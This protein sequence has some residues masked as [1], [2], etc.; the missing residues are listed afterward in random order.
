M[1]TSMETFLL[2][3]DMTL[4]SHHNTI[5]TLLYYAYLHLFLRWLNMSMQTLAN[6]VTLLSALFV[7]IQRETIDAGL[8][9]LSVSYALQ[10]RT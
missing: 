7:V 4:I 5:H 8:A 3:D 10:V 2:V 1:E 9:G 6:C